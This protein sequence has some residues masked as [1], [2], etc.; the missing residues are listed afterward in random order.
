MLLCI[1][2]VLIGVNQQLERK[3]KSI[4]FIVYWKKQHSPWSRCEASG[5]LTNRPGPPSP[6]THLS[7]FS[8]AS[9]HLLR[10]SAADD[11]ERTLSGSK[12]GFSEYLARITF[13]TF[14]GIL[15]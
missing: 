12:S 7:Y 8:M 6:P 4:L 3:S 15:S 2:R 5:E 1:S 10:P 14:A 9:T 13:I 11:A